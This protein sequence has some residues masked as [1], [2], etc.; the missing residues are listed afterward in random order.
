M[1]PWL[2]RSCGFA[3]LVLGACGG[4][5]ETVVAI[6]PLPVGGGTFFTD[7]NIGF[8]D[9]GANF[10]RVNAVSGE[11]AVQPLPGESE[12]AESRCPALFALDLRPDGKVLAVGRRSADLFE[13]DVRATRCRRLGAL[14]EVMAALAVRADGHLFTVSVTNRLYQF[15]ALAQ[16]LGATPLVC[17]PNAAPC[18]VD[19]I[20]F[21]PDGTLYA[22]GAL[23]LWSRITLA[24][25]QLTTLRTGVGF[26]DDFDIDAQGHVRGLKSGELRT[27]DLAGNPTRHAINVFGGTA[28]ATGVVHR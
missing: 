18:R 26:G 14:A 9:V 4:G 15:D 20:D 5:D 6:E 13:A 12:S 3:L 28:F 1:N 24:T 11:T 19:G 23:G 7:G 17:A 22:V 10:Y 16:P 21:G 25:G 8:S 27:F 2:A